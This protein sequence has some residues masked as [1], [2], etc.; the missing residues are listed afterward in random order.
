[1]NTLERLDP[2]LVGAVACG[3]GVAL[4][5]LAGARWTAAASAERTGQQM[6]GR[7]IAVTSVAVC[8]ERAD[9]D[10]ERAAR[11]ASAPQATTATRQRDAMMATGYVAV[12]RNAAASGALPTACQAALEQHRSALVPQLNRTGR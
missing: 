1:M 4:V 12:V 5:G 11:L 6:A 3:V 2:G 7:Q 10:A 8:V 9:A